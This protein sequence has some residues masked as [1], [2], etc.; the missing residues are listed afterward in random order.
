MSKEIFCEFFGK[1]GTAKSVRA[2]FVATRTAEIASTTGAIVPE[3]REF[4]KR[5]ASGIFA[6]IAETLR[7]AFEA[8]LERDFERFEAVF[9]KKQKKS[10]KRL[11][12][13]LFILIIFI[14]INILLKRKFQKN[15]FAAKL[16]AK[17]NSAAKLAANRSD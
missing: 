3:R 2:D 10:P 14:N 4:C 11:F 16:A 17:R 8:A 15:F 6:K 7:T 9:P 5:I 1:R 13:F 12:I